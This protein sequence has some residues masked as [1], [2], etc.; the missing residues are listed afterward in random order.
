MSDTQVIA[1]DI[2]EQETV[3]AAVALMVVACPFLPSGVVTRYED[4]E[5]LPYSVGVFPQSGSVYVKQ[6]VSGSL[7]GQYTFQLLYRLPGGADDDGRVGAEHLLDC[8]AQWLEAAEATYGGE[9]YQM[10][11]YPAL[12]GGRTVQSIERTS[13]PVLLGQREDGSL[14]YSIFLQLRYFKK[15]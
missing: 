7:I 8:I 14:D 13:A 1:L 12:S 9:T 3:G 4:M 6:F 2:S 5:G 15:A 11:G 10:G